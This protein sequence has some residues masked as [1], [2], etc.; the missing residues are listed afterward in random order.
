MG[1]AQRDTS[2]LQTFGQNGRQSVDPF[3]DGLQTLWAV[4]DRI[5][6]RHI[7]KQHLRRTDVGVGLFAADMLFARLQRHAIGRFTARIFG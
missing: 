3:G 6:T 2:V 5:K 7:G 1:R 4:I